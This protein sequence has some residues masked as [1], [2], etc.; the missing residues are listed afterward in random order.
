MGTMTELIHNGLHMAP[1]K[2]T[3]EIV[4]IDIEP[5]GPATPV[6]YIGLCELGADGPGSPSLIRFRSPLCP[7]P[8][9]EWTTR[10]EEEVQLADSVRTDGERE[11]LRGRWDLIDDIDNHARLFGSA[12]IPNP[13][14]QPEFRRP[15]PE[16]FDRVWAWLT[17]LFAGKVLTAYN[18]VY[19]RSC[20]S[21]MVQAAGCGALPTHWSGLTASP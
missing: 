7:T 20:L 14:P 17:P 6:G 3:G 9:G 1:G 8:W 16:P 10:C 4:S 21:D 13:F 2:S 18:A 11:I 5:G 15:E 12:P 19:D